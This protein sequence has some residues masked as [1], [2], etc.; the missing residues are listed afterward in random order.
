MAAPPFGRFP[1]FLSLLPLCSPSFA[2][3]YRSLVSLS[4]LGV[5]FRY[6][7]TVSPL[8]V[9]LRCHLPLSDPGLLP[10]VAFQSLLPLSL[11]GVSSRSHLWSMPPGA[12]SGVTSGVDFY[13]FLSHPLYFNGVGSCSVQWCYQRLQWTRGDAYL[14]GHRRGIW[15]QHPDAYQTKKSGFTKYI[16]H[17]LLEVV[18]VH[19]SHRARHGKKDEYYGKVLDRVVVNLPGSVWYFMHSPTTNTMRD[20]VRSL[21]ADRW[22]ANKRNANSSEILETI[23][24]KGSTPGKFPPWNAGDVTASSIWGASDGERSGQNLGRRCWRRPESKFN[25]T[26]SP[27]VWLLETRALGA[28]DQLRGNL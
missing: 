3:R 23:G 24:P 9:S 19:N 6:S 7:L 20:N 17:M 8:G 26:F 5:S 25:R 10:G 28:L 11:L 1:A 16:K 18:L 4:R 12:T 14:S 21:M 2:S 27:F 15:S 13:S 22:E